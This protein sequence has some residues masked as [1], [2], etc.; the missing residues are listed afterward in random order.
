M[1]QVDQNIS[2]RTVQVD[3]AAALYRLIEQTRDQLSR[4]LPWGE[5]TRSV[6]DERKFLKYCQIRIAEKALWP[7]VIL[8]DQQVA[9]M[10]D[11]HNFDPANRNCEIGYW[12]GEPFQHNGVMIKV[13]EQALTIA[14]TELGMHKV[15]LLAEVENVASNNVAQRCGFSLS[16]TLK[17]HIYSQGQFHDANVYDYIVEENL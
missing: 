17:D 6:D 3:D 8:V 2:L 9:G 1:W 12:L 5:T 13:V 14:A 10:F 16:G 4:F 7:V 11:F 15:M